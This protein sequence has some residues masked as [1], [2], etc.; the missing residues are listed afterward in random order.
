MFSFLEKLKAWNIT[1]VFTIKRKLVLPY[2]LQKISHRTDISARIM[3]KNPT[4]PFYTCG[5]Q[6]VKSNYLRGTVVYIPY[7]CSPTHI[8]ICLVIFQFLTAEVR[9]A[10][11]IRAIN[12]IC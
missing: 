5:S 9:T 4:Q 12:I 7:T 1:T 10:F 2:F 11:I 6:S 8:I 3:Q